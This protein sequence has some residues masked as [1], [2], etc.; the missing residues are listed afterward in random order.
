MTDIA[1]A[2][3]PLNDPRVIWSWALYDWANSAFNTLVAT[4]IYSTYFTQAMAPDEL[5]GTL[6]WSRAV[7][8][9]GILTALVSPVLGAAAGIGTH[10]RLLDHDSDF[11]GARTAGLVPPSSPNAAMLA[12]CLRDRDLVSDRLCLL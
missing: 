9:S 1:P 6:W 10:K 2:H 3:A 8:I 12:S 7:A 4:F 5:R 11:T